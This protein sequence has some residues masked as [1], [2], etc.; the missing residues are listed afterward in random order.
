M[1]TT[2]PR[3]GNIKI[4]AA[5]VALTLAATIAVSSIGMFVTYPTDAHRTNAAQ[6][7]KL[8]NSAF[9]NGSSA[10]VFETSE[11]KDLAEND[12][13]DYS[14][15]ATLYSAVGELIASIV[16]IGLTYTYLRSRRVTKHAVG[17][18]V[19]LLS[20]SSLISSIILTAM[21]TFVIGIEPL[22]VL[23]LGLTSIAGILFGA[24]VVYVIARIFD[25][26]YNRKH[27][28]IVE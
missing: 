26:R 8:Q 24:L 12:L 2:K 15:M 19:L 20:I 4:Y 23:V 5:I 7:S 13:A 28:F 17:M 1:T 27:S 25:W 10:N 21:Q 11:Y 18:T 14:N 22:S 9:S 3:P 6:L 16:I